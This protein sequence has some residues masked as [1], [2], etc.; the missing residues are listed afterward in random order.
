MFKDEFYFNI[1]NNIG[2]NNNEKAQNALSD[3]NWKN[4]CEF[5]TTIKS[6]KNSQYKNNED[7]LSF[8]IWPKFNL[9]HDKIYIFL[10]STPLKKINVFNSGEGDQGLFII[11]SDNKCIINGI[12]SKKVSDFSINN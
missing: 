1:K 5:I 6:V 8:S 11:S 4:K 2:T 3:F 12:I 7:A 10:T 9:Y